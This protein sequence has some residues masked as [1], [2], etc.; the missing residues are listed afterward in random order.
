M[1]RS[2][3]L[4]I[5]LALLFALLR[6]PFFHLHGGRDHGPHEPGHHNL[7]LILHTHLQASSTSSDHALVDV[8][9]TG[10]SVQAVDILL[11]E[12]ESPASLPIQAEQLAFFSPLVPVGLTI[13]ELT[14][15]IHDPP[16]AYPSIPR[17]PPA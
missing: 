14:P 5:I 13:Y 4:S 1:R 3:A 10:R 12:Q 11:F 2:V 8:P 9:H 15:R 6:A 16:W 17:S 7:V